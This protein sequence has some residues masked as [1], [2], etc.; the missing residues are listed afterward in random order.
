MDGLGDGREGGGGGG[1]Q[2]GLADCLVLL[3]DSG[4]RVDIGVDVDEVAGG[5][6]LRNRGGGGG[7]GAGV[8]VGAD[9]PS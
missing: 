9:P 7:G 4:Y 8:Y 3:Q 5:F 2:G 6:G 1:G